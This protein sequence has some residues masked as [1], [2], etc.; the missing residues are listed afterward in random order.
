MSQMK[1]L[2]SRVTGFAAPLLEWASTTGRIHPSWAFDTATGRL[3]CRTPNL[4]NLPS[5]EQDRYKVR[6]AFRPKEGSAFVVADYAQLELIILAHMSGDRSMIENLSTGGDY[7]SEV[8]VK[9]FPEIRS[10]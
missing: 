4:Q 1:G 6:E 9:I 8:A 2:K 7:H 3:A 10:A 5:A